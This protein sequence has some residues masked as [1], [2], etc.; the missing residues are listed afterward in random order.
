M[1]RF[2]RF[3][4]AERTHPRAGMRTGTC[5]KGPHFS[6]WAHPYPRLLAGYPPN[7]A[8]GHPD[9]GV[10]E[11]ASEG[12]AERVATRLALGRSASVGVDQ[13]S[14]GSE[15][16]AELVLAPPIAHALVDK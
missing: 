9:R 4:P 16:A 7:G 3:E 8:T 1:T 2:D 10:G 11:T 13:F 12:P 6:T 14:H 5:R 15:F